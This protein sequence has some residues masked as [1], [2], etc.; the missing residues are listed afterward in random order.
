MRKKYE[1]VTRRKKK[2]KKKSAI[3]GYEVGSMHICL[4]NSFFDLVE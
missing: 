1:F 2:K 4:E 3:R